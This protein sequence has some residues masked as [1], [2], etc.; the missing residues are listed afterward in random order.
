[1]MERAMALAEQAAAMGEVPVGCVVAQ[2]DIVVGS[3]HNRREIDRQATA[4]AEILAIGEACRSLRGWRLCGCDLFVTLEPCPMCAGAILN[5]RIDR[6]FFAVRDPKAGALLSRID[7]FAWGFNH[8]PEIVGG[9]M[10]ERS[11][12]LLTQ[13]FSSRRASRGPEKDNFS[14][15]FT[16]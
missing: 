6:V 11:S 2:G 15:N 16:T 9:L 10:A 8:R 14:N 12:A 13:F 5:A 1:M 3:G 7:L 4:H